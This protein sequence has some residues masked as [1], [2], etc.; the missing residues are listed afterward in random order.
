MSTIKAKAARIW[1]AT[2]V[3][4]K[5]APTRLTMA[6]TVVAIVLPVIGVPAVAAIAAPLAAGLLAAARI[7]RQVTPVLEGEQGILPKDEA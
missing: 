3:I 7:I 4:L 2:L 1:A 5:A 6:A